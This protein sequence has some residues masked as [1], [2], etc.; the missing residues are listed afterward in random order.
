[1]TRFPPASVL[2]YG[3]E[4]TFQNYAQDLEFQLNLCLANRKRLSPNVTS[5]GDSEGAMD[6]FAAEHEAVREAQ[7]AEPHFLASEYR[8]IRTQAESAPTDPAPFMEWFENLKKTGPGQGDPLFPWLAEEATYEQMRW[9]IGQEV[10]GE[11][12]FED[13]VALTQ[14]RLETPV[15]LELAR[16]YWDEMGRGNRKGMHGPMLG[17]LAEELELGE[18][19]LE[20]IVPEALAL[21]NL[22]VAL[23]ANR[24]TAYHSLGCLGV[25]ELTAPDRARA[26]YEGLKRLGISPTGQRYY[27]LHSTLDVQHSIQ[28]NREA[29]APLLA[30]RPECARAVA[31]GA[32]LRL[33]AGARCFRRY[34]RELGLALSERTAAMA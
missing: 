28:W 14:I 30:A 5:L 34:R 7:W 16:N 26:V 17:V 18:T 21:G 25:V 9:F 33:N 31:E 2:R 23:A 24:A 32:L 29:L 22:M 6:A 3:P 4:M 12:G 10:A 13:L 20:T 15:K 8:D 27:L 19:Q 1:M 11:A